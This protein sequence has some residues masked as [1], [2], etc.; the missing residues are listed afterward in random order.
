MDFH[1]GKIQKYFVWLIIAAAIFFR[2]NHYL[3]NL[4]FWADEAWLAIDLQRRTFSDIVLN[5]NISSYYAVP[6]AGF[7]LILKLFVLFF[8]NHEFSYRL[9]ALICSIASLSLFWRMLKK[10]SSGTTAIIAIAIFAFCDQVIF[11]SAQLKQYSSD[12]LITI[13]IWTLAFSSL[14]KPLRIHQII[15]IC[16]LGWICILVSHPAILAMTGIA[17]AQIFFKKERK[18]LLKQQLVIFISW[19]LFF[20]FAYFYYYQMNFSNPRMISC[21]NHYFLS[22]SEL[23]KSIIMIREMFINPGGLQ[24]QIA[25]PVFSFGVW[26]LA[27]TNKNLFFPLILPVIIAFFAAF[28]NKYPFGGRFLLFL[29]PALFIFIGEGFSF[30]LKK[31][32]L[33]LPGSVFLFL[34]LLPHVSQSFHHI[35][36]P[37]YIAETRPLLEFLKEE[38]K[39]DDVIYLNNEAQYA[40]HYYIR[41]LKFKQKIP[42]TGIFNDVTSRENAG[43]NFLY[44]YHCDRG[45]DSKMFVSG[46]LLPGRIKPANHNL[47]SLENKGRAWVLLAQADPE[48][49]KHIVHTFKNEGALI[50]NER[51]PG[52][53]LYLFEFCDEKPNYKK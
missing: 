8:G 47:A 11:Q 20:L 22:L 18:A 49:E 53:V 16:L 43:E 4:S 33:L 12:I 51:W 34:L 40:Y 7:L 21:Q 35:F 31:K 9:L 50:T 37:R 52:A 14:S 42:L 15:F 10:N 38:Q 46:K 23:S 1:T 2:L 19:A 5:R 28:L 29:V 36:K 27:K 13:I 39:S 45:F 44:L 30:L 6:P 25:F 41:A 32:A 26:H 48:A 17:V 24:W 3:D